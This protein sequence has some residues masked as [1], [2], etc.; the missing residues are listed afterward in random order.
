M[1][2][3]HVDFLGIGA[4]K[5]GTTWLSE[6]LRRHPQIWMPPVKE[7]HYFD[8]DP[9]YPS[10]SFLASESLRDRFFGQA[11]PDRDFRRLSREHLRHWWK[12][13]DWTA[14]RWGLRYF[15]GSRNDPWYRSLF[16]PGASRIT[17]E[18]TP[19]Y[20]IL[21]DADVGRV[22]KSFPNLQ[23]ILL[24]RNPIDR[25][26]S[27]LRFEHGRGRITSL[28]DVEA[29]RA[30]IDSPEQTLRSDYLRTLSIWEKHFPTPQLHVAFYDD[31]AAR[32]AE[33]L[34]A[35]L[36]HLGANPDQLQLGKEDLSRRVL[37]SREA[38]MPA[39]IRGFLQE[40]YRPQIATLAERFTD[41]PRHWLTALED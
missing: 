40:T 32:P 26:W 14:L 39:A 31:I 34:R 25:A 18:I 23:I 15:F 27:H 33:L 20:S 1:S 9:R 10:P 17:G 38:A 8:R 30:F 28:D 19:S 3:G 37:A 22:A 6:M 36:Q 2:S 16:A 24:L 41:P 35:I 13:R 4:Q 11:E 7:L 29:V 5:A 21:D 12:Q